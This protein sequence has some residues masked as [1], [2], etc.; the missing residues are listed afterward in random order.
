MSIG[1]HCSVIPKQGACSKPAF[2]SPQVEPL[3]SPA[4]EWPLHRA[5][6]SHQSTIYVATRR[7]G[8]TELHL[9]GRR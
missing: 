3:I 4:R 2:C 8:A 5:P 9:G 1:T 7:I 6:Q